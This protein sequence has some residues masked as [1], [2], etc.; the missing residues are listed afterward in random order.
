M[1]PNDHSFLQMLCATLC[2]P[3][4]QLQSIRWHYPTLHQYTKAYCRL[5]PSG[6]RARLVLPWLLVFHNHYLQIALENTKLRILDPFYKQTHRNDH[7]RSHLHRCQ[8]Q[9]MR[10]QLHSC[11]SSMQQHHHQLELGDLQLP[12]L[13]QDLAEGILLCLVDCLIACRQQLRLQSL[14]ILNI[15]FLLQLPFQNS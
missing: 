5:Q 15:E 12:Y 11:Y 1:R 4:S 10:S 7:S 9:P 14:V 2:L 3:S 8:G 6:R 13:Q